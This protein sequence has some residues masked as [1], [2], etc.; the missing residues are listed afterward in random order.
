MYFKDKIKEIYK[1]EEINIFV[2]MDGVIADYDFG[3]ILDFKDK[4]AI[5]TNIK[6]LEDLSEDK[7]IN[8]YILSICKKNNQI[9]DKNNWLNK[10]ASFFDIDK[11]YIISKEEYEGFSSKEIKLTIIKE[12]IAK[13]K[14]KNVVLIDDDNSILKYLDNSELNIRLFQ[15][16]SL[17]D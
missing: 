12:I 4:R 13:L 3:N 2:D 15:D 10:H 16:S 1:D 7:N 14:L 17:I 6:T 9:K 11:R 5:T 8:L